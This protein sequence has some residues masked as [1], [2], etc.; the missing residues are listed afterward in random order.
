M[1]SSYS[2]T[3]TFSGLSL[4][5]EPLWFD[6]EICSRLSLSGTAF[7]PVYIPISHTVC[8]GALGLSVNL[9]RMEQLLKISSRTPFRGTSQNPPNFASNATDT[10]STPFLW[11]EPRA[12]PAGVIRRHNQQA[13]CIHL[14]VLSIPLH[15]LT[16]SGI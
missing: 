16:L 9:T 1:N 10:L 8:Q 15:S 14:P 6:I 13:V 7:D 2:S 11:F 3:L 12:A 5:S 4:W